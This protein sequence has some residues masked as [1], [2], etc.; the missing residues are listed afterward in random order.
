MRL[1]CFA[2]AII[3]HIQTYAQQTQVEAH[4]KKVGCY[5]KKDGLIGGGAQQL[6]LNNTE[7]NGQ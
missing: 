6:F 4:L 7:Q 3:N 5:N 1:S 2:Q